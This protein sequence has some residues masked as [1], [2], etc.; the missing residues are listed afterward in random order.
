MQH[1]SILFYDSVDCEK[2]RKIRDKNRCKELKE[3]LTS[4]NYDDFINFE[5]EVISS[6]LSMNVFHWW[7]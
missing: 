5:I 3:I 1:F 2:K 4:V 6:L 7:S